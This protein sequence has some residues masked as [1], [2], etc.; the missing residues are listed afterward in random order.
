M[1]V[2]GGFGIIVGVGGVIVEDDG[3]GVLCYGCVDQFVGDFGQCFVLGD[4]FLFVF[5]VFVDVFEWI[6]DVCF[7]ELQCS[8]VSVFL[9]FEL[10]RFLGVIDDDFVWCGDG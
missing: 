3:F 7:G 2:V 9:V 5:V 1:Y 4:V 6:F 10:V 8:V